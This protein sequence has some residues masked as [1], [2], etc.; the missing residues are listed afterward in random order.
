MISNKNEY[1]KIRDNLF[2]ALLLTLIIDAACIALGRVQ[3]ITDYSFTLHEMLY[4]PLYVSMILIPILLIIFL[5]NLIKNI[6]DIWKGTILMDLRYKIKSLFCILCMAFTIG[7]IFCQINFDESSAVYAI[8]NRIID[9][10]NTYLMVN[11]IKLKCTQNEYNL[12]NVNKKYFIVYEWNRLN[13]SIGKLK[14][15]E[16]TVYNKN[17]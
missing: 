7:L 4:L 6:K 9:E 1:L 14:N 10:K 3:F 17:K 13:P 2:I 11:N 12:I 5:Y 8:T 15:I 16:L